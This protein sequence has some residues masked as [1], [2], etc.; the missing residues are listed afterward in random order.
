MHVHGGC[1][2]SRLFVPDYRQ[3]VQEAARHLPLRNKAL[4]VAFRRSA[5]AEWT[6]VF[7][8]G[9][10]PEAGEAQLCAIARYKPP[11]GDLCG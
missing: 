1:A 5:G 11:G 2:N 4:W 7:C 3:A 8:S 6:E 10:V 9:L